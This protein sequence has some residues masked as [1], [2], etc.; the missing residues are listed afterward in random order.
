M[1]STYVSYG[2]KIIRL[3]RS[4]KE[5]LNI[6]C[7]QQCLV[8]VSINTFATNASCKWPW[9]VG[10]YYSVMR[11]FSFISLLCC[12]LRGHCLSSAFR[13]I[14]RSKK[15]YAKHKSAT[16]QRNLVTHECKYLPMFT[17]HILTLSVFKFYSSNWRLE[18]QLSVHQQNF[19]WE[20]I[21][22]IASGV[23]FRSIGKYLSAFSL[24]S[25]ELISS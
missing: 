7:Q 1:S 17:S 14:S 2:L 19:Y 22:L 24:S 15:T 5:E 10:R 13:Y 6:N 23:L 20:T 9:S 16:Q 18:V 4:T 21:A 3:V 11:F 25:T 8:P 12:V